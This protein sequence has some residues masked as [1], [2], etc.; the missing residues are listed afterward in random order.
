MTPGAYQA[1]LGTN[2]NQA[3]RG[4]AFEAHL[5]TYG[6]TADT[7]AAIYNGVLQR[8]WFNAQARHFP[9]TLDAALDGNAEQD[10]GDVQ[11][12]ERTFPVATNGASSGRPDER[13]GRANGSGSGEDQV[14]EPGY[15]RALSA[16]F[17]R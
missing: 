1:A 15:W 12:S 14:S 16:L 5:K 17:A 6:A 9:T 11:R 10:A 8:G 7:Y 4:K 2:R 13:A 3:D